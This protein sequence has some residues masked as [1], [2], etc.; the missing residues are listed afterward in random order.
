MNILHTLFRH[1]LSNAAGFAITYFTGSPLGMAAGPLIH[2]ISQV[3]RQRLIAAKQPIP[4]YLDI[5][6]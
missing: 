2:Y 3:E 6:P 5:L 4:W 1:I